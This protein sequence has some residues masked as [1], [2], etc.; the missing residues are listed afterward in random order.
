MSRRRV[1]WVLALTARLVLLAWPAAL[2]EYRGSDLL[3]N[4]S[5]ESLVAGGLADRTRCRRTGSTTT[6]TSA[7]PSPMAWRRRS[8]TGPPRSCGA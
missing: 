3:G 1:A 8:H 4:I 7:S 6:S 2:A 5:P